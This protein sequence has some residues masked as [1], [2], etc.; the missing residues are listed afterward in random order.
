MNENSNRSISFLEL[1]TTNPNFRRVLIGEAASWLGDW[2]GAIAMYTLVRDL[3]G[4]PFALGLVFITKILPFAI[5]SPLAGLLVDRF[6]RRRLMIGTDLG[7]AVLVLGF[8]WVD[9]ADDLVILYSL[10]TLQVFLTA[11][12]IPA[13]SASIPNITTPKEFADSQRAVC[14]HLVHSPRGRR[15]A[16][17]FCHRLVGDGLGLCDR[18]CDLR[19]LRL[20]LV[21]NGDS[22]TYRNRS[23][24]R[25]RRRRRRDTRRVAFHPSS[26][27]G[28]QD[29]R[30]Q[31]SVG[32]RWW[33][34]GLHAGPDR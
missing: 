11:V 18:Q 21:S 34:T 17:R 12:F 13:R 16:R 25:C 10:T 5:A 2:F 22:S 1:L 7:R 15:G 32:D 8:L 33:W 30:R 23:A 27:R 14:R 3:T 29:G 19:R 9:S 24:E 6:N 26:P 4:S 20:V 28:R 31:G